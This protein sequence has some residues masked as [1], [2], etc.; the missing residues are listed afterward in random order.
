MNDETSPAKSIDSASS[1]R[2]SIADVKVGLAIWLVTD[3]I[4]VVGVTF[5]W[6]MVRPTKDRADSL[7]A[8][9]AQWDGKRYAS[10]V[11]DGYSYRPG[12]FSNV[13]FF[14]L[15]PAIAQIVVRGTGADSRLALFL[16]AQ[17]F[18]ALAF[19]ALHAYIR[20]RFPK[21]PDSFARWLLLV[22]AL[23]PTTFFFRMAY[24]E[25]LF[26]LLLILVLLTLEVRAPLIVTAFFV[27]CATATRPVGVALIPV[28]LLGIG[29]R[30]ES[31]K[32]F[33]GRSLVLLP[34]ACSGLAAFIFYQWYALDDPFAF[35]RAQ[36]TWQ[37]HPDVSWSEKAR[38]LL[39]LEPIWGSVLSSSR[40]CDTAD[41]AF[42]IAAFGASA[43]NA[44]LFVMGV[45]LIVFGGCK[46]WLTKAELVASAGLLF[47]PYLLRGYD[48][49]FLSF[50]RFTAVVFPI[51]IPLTMV[52]CRLPQLAKIGLLIVSGCLMTIVC[53]LFA[54]GYYLT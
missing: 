22:V 27:G 8:A 51:Y 36:K 30:S 47:I 53:A 38:A 41:M 43:L 20:I 46:R 45:F 16:V 4:V 23:F 48:S 42:G 34:V 52:V 19:V 31:W 3:V 11:D 39:F 35:V 44:A 28:L 40:H 26:L 15:Y 6:L 7:V 12:D 2:I 14:P 33:F 50:A 17:F 18:L 49:C 10:I 21:A 13:A 5:G 24:S 37:A 29:R 9:F 25:S 1:A 54:A 32:Q